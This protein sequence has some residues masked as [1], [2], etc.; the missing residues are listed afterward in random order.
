MCAS[1]AAPSDEAACLLGRRIFKH[2]YDS[3]PAAAGSKLSLQFHGACLEQLATIA[4]AG[5]LGRRLAA[6]AP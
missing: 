1:G 3:P 4:G 2:L 6:S 5:R